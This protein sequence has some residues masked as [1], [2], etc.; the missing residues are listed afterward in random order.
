MLYRF[1]DALS[2]AVRPAVILSGIYFLPAI[3]SAA[4][5]IQI[6]GN[7]VPIESGDVTPRQYDGTDFGPIQANDPTTLKY[8]Y[9]IFNSG[10][11]DLNITDDNFVQANGYFSEVGAVENVVPAGEYRSLDI[12]YDPAVVGTDTATVN[13]VTDDPDTPIYS[14]A[15]RGEGT[16]EA[17]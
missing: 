5:D 10:D 15:V 8:E 17:P 6:T 3:A 7:F 12:Q 4:P 14:F 1:C 16:A 2:I 13:I 9:F 11:T